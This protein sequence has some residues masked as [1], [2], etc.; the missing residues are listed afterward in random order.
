MTSYPVYIRSDIAWTRKDIDADT[1]E[2]AIELARRL[3]EEN[4]DSLELDF[5][6]LTALSDLTKSRSTTTTGTN[7]PFGMTTTC[8]CVSRRVTYSTL[9]KRFAT[10]PRM[11]LAKGSFR[12]AFSIKRGPRLPKRRAVHNHRSMALAHKLCQ[13]FRNGFS[14]IELML[15]SCATILRIRRR[16]GPRRARPPR[17]GRP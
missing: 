10:F 16:V 2:L 15:A 17:M 1:P 3:A 4:P 6:D 5:Y 14:A 11:T 13:S 7:L 9:W 8:A 12:L